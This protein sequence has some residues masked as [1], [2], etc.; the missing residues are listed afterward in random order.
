MTNCDKEDIFNGEDMVRSQELVGTG[1]A[2]AQRKRWEDHVIGDIKCVG[3]GGK[4]EEE[5]VNIRTLIN[6]SLHVSMV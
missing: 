4:R 2:C 1:R 3:I 5:E 6:N